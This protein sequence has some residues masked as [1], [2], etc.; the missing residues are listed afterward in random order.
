[1][2]NETVLY[3]AQLQQVA[4]GSFA[5]TQVAELSAAVESD[6]VASYSLETGELRVPC[7][8]EVNPPEVAKTQALVLYAAEEPGSPS[9]FV[10]AARDRMVRAADKKLSVAFLQ[11]SPP[12]DMS[13][14]KNCGQTSVLMVMSF[15]KGVSPTVQGIKDIDDWLYQKY[16]DPVNNYNGSVTTV[17]KLLVVAK[18]KGGFSNSYRTSG[19]GLTE[20]KQQ[21]DQGHPVITAVT[22]GYLSN[23]GYN[24]AGGHFVVVKGYTSTQMIVNDPG[25]QWGADKYYSNQD[26][27]KAFNAQ[28]GAA[29]VV[30][31]GSVTQ[32]LA[33]P[34]I[35]GVTLTNM[36]AT[37]G[38]KGVPTA[39]KY[40][41]VISQDA[42]FSG[43]TDA[44]GYSTCNATCF[45]DITSMTSFTK[46][47]NFRNWTYYVKVRAASDT[48]A[49]S[50]S[51]TVSFK[52]PR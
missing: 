10:R 52:T 18:E 12:G 50:W 14:T 48:A 6:C 47:M 5:L 29:V 30:V 21:I 17:D 31:G 22:S 26:F 19:W 3:S 1:M 40:R 39:N 8:E 7:V 42:N 37:I 4:E 23:R 38:W 24:Y 25:T 13:N 45:T 32:P 36:N 16:R 9:V 35:T 2:G 43:F 20:L 28:G 15:Y 34:Q 49:S 27:T 11:Q 33:A 51:S 46:T 44:N 41:I